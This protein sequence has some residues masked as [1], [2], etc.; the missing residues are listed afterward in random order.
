VEAAISYM[1]EQ[2][3][4]GDR[5][6]IKGSRGVKLDRLADALRAAAEELPNGQQ[7]S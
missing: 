4:P 7:G 5:I 6:L 1:Q 3:R 2:Q